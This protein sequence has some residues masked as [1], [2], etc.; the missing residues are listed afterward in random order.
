MERVAK[1]DRVLAYSHQGV[2]C[3]Y[4]T[5]LITCSPIHHIVSSVADSF[6]QRPLNLSYV[7]PVPISIRHFSND[8]WTSFSAKGGYIPTFYTTY[9]H[10]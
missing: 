1:F 2:R 7:Q 4:R 8:F 5:V 10:F 3:E 6:T 9:I